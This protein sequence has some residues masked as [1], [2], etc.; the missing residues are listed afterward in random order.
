MCVETHRYRA[1][2]SETMDLR[3][4]MP[5]FTLKTDHFPIYFLGNP[6]HVS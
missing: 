6:I 2:F 1:H 4:H 3:G 5:R